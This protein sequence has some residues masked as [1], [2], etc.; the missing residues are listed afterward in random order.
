ME[1]DRKPTMSDPGEYIC[2]HCRRPIDPSRSGLRHFGFFIAHQEQEC[3]D[4]L[5]AEIAALKNEFAGLAKSSGAVAADFNDEFISVMELFHPNV[6]EDGYGPMAPLAK[7]VAGEIEKLKTEIE[8]LREGY[9]IPAASS[10]PCPGCEYRDGKLVQWCGLHA[11]LDKLRA[12]FRSIAPNNS[13]GYDGLLGTGQALI[14]KDAEIAGLKAALAV[15][16]DI[17]S[18]YGLQAMELRQA[19]AQLADSVKRGMERACRCVCRDC[20]VSDKPFMDGSEFYHWING[21]FGWCQATSIRSA[22]A[23]IEKVKP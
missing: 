13:K 4:I 9:N 16:K 23:E 21:S 11:E 17:E 18:A 5:E 22:M 6:R 3:L 19:K 15:Y 1:N 2:G 8:R 7:I 10:K 14:D 12:V 20:A